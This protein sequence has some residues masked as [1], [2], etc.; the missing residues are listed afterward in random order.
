[1]LD[2]SRRLTF[3]VLESS[4]N[5]LNLVLAQMVDIV[6][7]ASQLLTSP[8]Q[9][10]V[11]NR[12]EAIGQAGHLS[13]GIRQ[14]EVFVRSEELRVGDRAGHRIRHCRGC[15]YW[16]LAVGDGL[17]AES[18]WQDDEAQKSERTR[19]HKRHRSDLLSEGDAKVVKKQDVRGRWLGKSRRLE[20][21]MLSF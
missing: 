13:G 16:F 21:I 6:R 4:L 9:R 2:N 20:E 17:D 11:Q 7:L 10:R 1:V 5:L 15:W 8:C 3:E 12:G 18:E 19:V 14:L